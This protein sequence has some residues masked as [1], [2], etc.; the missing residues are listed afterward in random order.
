MGRQLFLHHYLPAF[1]YSVLLSTTLLDFLGGLPYPHLPR[2]T[3]FRRWLVRTPSM[4]YFLVVFS[5]IGV[6]IA[7]FTYFMPLTYGTG[8][9]TKSILQTRKWFSSWDL[10][11]A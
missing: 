6:I 11:H 7:G 3:P 1:I 5:V 10:Q 4:P 2:T 9:P 8:F